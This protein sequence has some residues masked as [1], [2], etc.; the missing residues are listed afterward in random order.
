MLLESFLER[1]IRQGSLTVI[2][3]AGRRR[4][5]GNGASPAAAKRLHDRRLAWQ[6]ALSPQLAAGEAYMDGR[7][8]I[9]EGSLY[10]FID[11]AASNLNA[12][13]GDKLQGLNHALAPVRRWLSAN[14]MQRA[15]KNVAHHYDLTDEL[16]ALFLDSDQ[17]YSCAYFAPGVTGLEAAQ[18]AKLRHI[19]AK[20]KLDRPG[21][22]L[23]DIGSG[24]GGMGLYL[25]GETG[26]D[27]TGV[28]LSE[29]QHRVSNERARDSGLSQ[30]ARF[31]LRDYRQEDGRYERIVS[32]GM[33]EHVD[34][35]NLDEYF[36]KLGRLM[37]EDGVALLHSIGSMGSPAPV[38]PWIRKYIF[39]GGYLP[40]LSE[41]LAAIERARLWVTDIK[42]LRLHYAETL[43][44]WRMRFQD[45]REQVKALYDERFCRMWEFYL[46]ASEVSFRRLEQMVF[47]IQLAHRR[48]AAPI[49]RDYILDWE[50]SLPPAS[51]QAAD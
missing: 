36:V 2:D 3:A 35:R 37:T 4:C 44:A 1:V 30:R 16:Y 46:A 26:A 13:G 34:A 11:L 14:P 20:L 42:I 12:I 19:A 48:D 33:F 5:Y 18:Q 51:R 27:V 50:R 41:T 15:Q 25:A 39:P 43:R 22:K 24:W 38:N 6:L 45:N 47:Q 49:T 31:H 10:D 9:E 21:L 29:R 7:L 17:Q 28:T 32:V 8:T 23:L 40:S